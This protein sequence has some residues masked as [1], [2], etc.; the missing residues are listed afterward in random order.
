MKQSAMLPVLGAGMTV[1]LLV[2][3]SAGEEMGPDFGDQQYKADSFGDGGDSDSYFDETTETDSGRTTTTYPDAGVA[4]AATDMDARSTTAADGGE[5][6]QPDPAEPDNAAATA[7]SLGKFIDSKKTTQELTIH[8][9]HEAGDEDWFVFDVEDAFDFS[10]PEP[11]VQVTGISADDKVEIAG[12]YTCNG[13]G[14]VECVN[15]DSN[16]SFGSGCAATGSG[17][18]GVLM[19]FKTKC[20]GT[21]ESG[22]MLVRIRSLQHGGG[23]TPYNVRFRVD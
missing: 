21:N 14:E 17:E 15:G 9:L 2:A 4:D 11:E 5:G 23:C 18:E 10:N 16:Q 6:C 7:T 8:T 19:E 22:T 20:E 3:C 12:W 13:G 1:A